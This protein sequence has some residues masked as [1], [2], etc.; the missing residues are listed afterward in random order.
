MSYLCDLTHQVLK[1]NDDANIFDTLINGLEKINNKLDP[2]IITN[3]IELKYLDYLGVGLNLDRCVKCNKTTNIITIDPDI[4]GFICKDCYTDETIVSLKTIK[5]IRMYY[6]IDISTITSIKISDIVKR[7][8]N[9][10]LNR[11]YERYT[12]LYLKSKDFLSKL[13]DISK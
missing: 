5:M 11:Y 9:D 12:G 10:F 1:E 4:G 2:L 8:I 13:V 3:I 6:L 7:E